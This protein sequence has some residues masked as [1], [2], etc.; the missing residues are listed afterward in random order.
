V[1]LV[2][3]DAPYL[4]RHNCNLVTTL[5]GVAQFYPKKRHNPSPKG[6]HRRV[7]DTRNANCESPEVTF[8]LH[9]K[10]SNIEGSFS[11]LKRDNS[12]AL[13]KILDERRK[14]K[15]FGRACNQNLKR[16]RQLNYTE[17]IS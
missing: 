13:R 17:N 9:H 15:T 16:L 6:Q 4:S 11:T 12:S 7:Q 1:D 5:D 14:Q 3:G 2:A 10:H 8:G